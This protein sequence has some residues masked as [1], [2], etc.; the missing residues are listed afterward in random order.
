LLAGLL[1]IFVLTITSGLAIGE[2]LK[3]FKGQ[4]L[5]VTS[6]SGSYLE[7][8]KNSYVKPFMRESG[9]IV[10]VSP[11]WAEFISKIKASPEDKPPYDVFIAD[12]WNYI[13]AMNIKRLQ[14]IRKENIPNA[15]D[16]YPALLQREPWVEGY[17]VPFDGG[18]YLPAYSPKAIGFKP[19]SWKDMLKPELHQKITMD[20]A[21]YYTLYAAAY[22]SD[23]KPGV[24]EL[25]SKEGLDEC[26]KVSARLAKS[27]KK[28]YA[29]GAE[30]L[31]L[32]QTGEVA[33]GAYYS[34]GVFGQQKKGVDIKMVLADEGVNAWIGYM[35]VMKGTKKRDLAEAFINYALGTER[36][37]D[38]SLESG[39][40]V[41]NSKAPVP[42]ALKGINPGTN[43]DFEKITFFDWGFL[44]AKWT[45]LEER[46]KKEVLTQAQ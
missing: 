3:R 42:A 21:F 35:T 22:I 45:E 44:N 10:V 17:G 1:L 11:G 6:W 8:F 26:F 40:W 36:Q 34:G 37:S 14:P 32:L 18:L 43:K 4:K 41:A 24:E 28:F 25:Y 13:A 7:Y 5:I 15:K 9:A 29:G 38:F 39:N 20:K 30:F 46:F 19:T 23:M 31:N 33:M 2:D 27:V 12:G 16:I